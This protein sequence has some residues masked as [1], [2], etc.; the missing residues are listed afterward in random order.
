[1]GRSKVVRRRTSEP[2][3][4]DLLDYFSYHFSKR[5]QLMKH[6]KLNRAGWWTKQLASG[7]AVVWL[8]AASAVHAATLAYYPFDGNM[9]DGSGNGNNLSAAGPTGPS[10]STGMFGSALS[11]SPT[12]G[13]GALPD[14]SAGAFDTTFTNFSVGMWMQPDSWTDAAVRIITGK[15]SSSS[16]QRGWFLQKLNGQLQFGSYTAASAGTLFSVT[17]PANSTSLLPTNSF[18]HVAGTYQNTGANNLKIY[19]NGILSVQTTTALSPFQGQNS[20]A[21]E[22]GN[23]GNASTATAFIGLLDD[24][25][26]A[27]DTIAAQQIA[28][29]HGLGRLAGVTLGSLNQALTNT[30]ILD[31]LAAY[32]AQS[33]AVAGEGPAAGTTW[34]YSANVGGGTTIGTIGGNVAGNDAFI[35]L[36]T[37]GSGVTLVPEPSTMI[38]FGMAF[39]SAAVW[40][41]R[42][43]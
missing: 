14:A 5:M 9:T 4:N 7:L 33:S 25:G 17:S 34:Y 8:G 32:G 31:V 21:F 28:L 2:P 38:L 20:N 10:F 35:V 26:V 19:I 24:Y 3:R 16:S 36:G 39:C 42:G 6:V 37:D 30:Q 13:W 22:V 27:S 40:L 18:T 11:T 15:T 1:M 41:R 12:T 23:R 29:T 43:I